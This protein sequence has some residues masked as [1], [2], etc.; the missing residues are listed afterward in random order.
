MKLKNILKNVEIN[1]GNQ[2]LFDLEISGIK[3]DS[4]K[5]KKGDLFI[6][7][8]GNKFD[9][10]NYINQALNNGASAVIS[11]KESGEN[12]INVPSARKAYALACKNYF[13]KACD[14]L[15]IIAVT[16]T[17]GKTTTCNM[18]ADVLSYA[19]FKVATIGT[20]G[21]G[22]DGKFEETGFTTPDPHLL[23]SI[24]ARLYKA[25]FDFVVMETSAH[26]LELDKLEGIKFEAGAITNITEDHLDYFEDMR[27][28]ASAKF[29]LFDSNR[30]KNGVMMKPLAYSELLTK[31][32]TKNIYS[33][34][35]L[36]D[37]DYCLTH[38]QLEADGSNFTL[39]T[40][41]GKFDF[42]LPLIGRY[43]IDNALL[44]IA[45]CELVGVKMNTIQE[46]LKQ[47]KEVPG[48][49]NKLS[50]KNFTVV[51]DYA[52]TPDGLENILKTLKMQTKNRLIVVF[53][54]GGN[55][56]KLKRPIMG[57]IAGKIADEII[58]TSDNP[59]YENP[60]KIIKEIRSGI[61]KKCKAFVSRKQAINYALS[62]AQ[63]G[64]TVLIAGKGAENEQEI[65]GIKYP[66]ND[67]KI[68][69]A[70]RETSQP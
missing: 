59:R 31:I 61:D 14:K 40:K 30:L 24:F 68:V 38:Y 64:D 65:N 8:K 70:W 34:G 12:I 7:L 36:G 39:C 56:D 25:N 67:K 20:L 47:I 69:S 29:K 49:M 37:C 23:H 55:R 27:A 52:H 1:A 62:H 48:R 28:Y 54:C 5:V 46:G 51:I 45:T 13:G 57:E 53:G 18:I 60:H 42:F 2:G 15:K 16:G 32:K 11:D 4:N 66:F 58:L 26:A 3:I 19:G 9:G 44:A 6:A 10:N 43:N 21:I 41:N 50:V 63:A 22:I 17:N 35:Q 33:C